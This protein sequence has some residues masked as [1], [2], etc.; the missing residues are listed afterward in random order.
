MTKS[1]MPK[2]SRRF[3][4]LFSEYLSC[5]WAEVEKGGSDPESWKEIEQA[6]SKAEA[7]LFGYIISLEQGQLKE[8]KVKKQNKSTAM[9]QTDLSNQREISEEVGMFQRI[10]DKGEYVIEHI[11]LEE[12]MERMAREG[13]QNADPTSVNT[14]DLGGNVGVN[15]NVKIEIRPDGE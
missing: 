1:N 13:K 6:L 10:N 9:Q 4:R 14:D 15:Q 5:F 12:H 11:S 8:T 7:D 2:V 3:N